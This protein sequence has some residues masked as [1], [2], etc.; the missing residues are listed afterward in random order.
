MADHDFDLR[1]QRVLRADAERAVRP[2]DPVAL[3]EAAVGERPDRPPPRL[4]TRRLAGHP[5]RPHCLAAPPRGGR[6]PFGSSPARRSARGSSRPVPSESPSGGRSTSPSSGAGSPPAPKLV[7]ISGT[8]MSDPFVFEIDTVGTQAYLPNDGGRER[9]LATV[10]AAGPDELR[11]VTRPGV[12]EAVAVDGVQ[13]AR[14]RRRRRRDVPGRPVTRRIAPDPDRRRGRL[15]VSSGRVRADL[16]AL[17]G[18]PNSGGL[19]VLDAFDPRFAVTLPTGSY[20]PDRAP[21]TIDIHQAAPEFEFVAWKDPQGFNDPCDPLGSGRRPINDAADFVAYFRQLPGFTVD[22]VADA[23]IDGH[24][25]THLSLHA[26]PD[27]SCPAGWLVEFQPAAITGEA[28]LVPASR[29][30]G[31]PVPRRPGRHDPDVRG[32]PGP[33]SPTIAGHC[34]DQV[35]RERPRDLALATR[36]PRPRRH[37][38]HHKEAP[39]VFSLPV[40]ARRVA[41]VLSGLSLVT[42]LAPAVV[43]AA[44]PATHPL[45][46]EPPDFYTC[47][48]VGAGTICRALTSDAVRARRDR[49]LLQRRRAARPGHPDHRRHP[50]LRRG[51]QPDPAGAGLRL[52]RHPS[53]QPGHRRDRL[54]PPAQH[55][56]GGARDPG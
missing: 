7:T 24:P 22:A 18:R 53:H 14:L 29:R 13:L 9:L 2:F 48:P 35:P 55:R 44:P 45:N 12:V 38:S 28:L 19:G 43:L 52:R 30:L 11:F 26:N 17:L 1:L 32:A 50:L 36:P 20:V 4:A 39:P 40:V 46:P 10:A 6:R 54:L 37:P 23:Q 27:A 5:P 8:L 41:T 51:R 42:V 15:S 47:K 16:D 56:L 21:G 31:Q 33:R 49:H 25:A 34:V 3:A